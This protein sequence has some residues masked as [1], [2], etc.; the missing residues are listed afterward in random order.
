[1]NATE[2]LEQISEALEVESADVG[3]ET[4]FKKLSNWD[5]MAILSIIAMVD[6]YHGKVLSGDDIN[7]SKTIGDLYNLI[8]SK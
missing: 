6:E 2:F 1:M 5:S 3:M 7:N 4:E 8:T